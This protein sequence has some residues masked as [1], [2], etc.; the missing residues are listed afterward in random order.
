[1]V[2]SQG[3]TGTMKHELIYRINYKATSDH[4]PQLLKKAEC[5]QV[6]ANV[7]LFKR[8]QNAA[9]K[10]TT[11][12]CFIQQ[13][14][15]SPLRVNYIYAFLFNKLTAKCIYLGKLRRQST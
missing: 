3:K 12:I 8:M 7:C 6:L 5:L 14:S 10:D 11:A 2:R 13:N 9:V 1:M 4:L 15:F